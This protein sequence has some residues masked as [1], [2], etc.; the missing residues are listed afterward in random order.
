[1]SQGLAPRKDVPRQG[2]S[3]AWVIWPGVVLI[4]ELKRVDII[5]QPKDIQ[6]SGVVQP[7]IREASARVDQAGAMGEE[8]AVTI[9]CRSKG[10]YQLCRGAASV[11][12]VDGAIISCDGVVED[13]RKGEEVRLLVAEAA[14]G[15]HFALP[16]DMVLME[17]R[18]TEGKQGAG[19][20]AEVRD[21]HVG[22]WCEL[23]APQVGQGMVP[24]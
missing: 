19:G 1:M 9:R 7:R 3:W 8:R 6:D 15:Q 14:E 5:P 13:P 20:R 11:I 2:G 17:A 10:A 16:V 23:A 24:Q 12:G 21:Q 22:V 18:V 4:P